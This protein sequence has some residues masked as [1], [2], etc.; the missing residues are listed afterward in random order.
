MNAKSAIAMVGLL[1]SLPLA[2]FAQSTDARQ[3]SALG[4]EC[5]AY[6]SG[7]QDKRPATMPDT[8]MAKSTMS[9]KASRHG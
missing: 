8:M 1:V 2:A 9:R 6:V 3:C 4:G 5:R 7:D